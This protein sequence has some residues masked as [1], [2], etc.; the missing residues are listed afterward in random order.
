MKIETLKAIVNAFNSA[1]DEAT[2]YHLNHVCLTPRAGM[3]TIRATDGHILANF[4]VEDE[5]FKGMRDK[6]DY[7]VSPDSL[8]MLKAL[9]KEFKN[10]GEVPS[11]ITD[12]AIVVKS[13]QVRIEFEHGKKD[14][15][16]FPDTQA[17]YPTYLEEPTQIAFNPELLMDL[18]KSLKEHEKQSGVVLVVKNKGA[19]IRVLCG[20][21]EGLLMPM[22]LETKTYCEK[23]E[24]GAA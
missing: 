11:E 10:C 2:R 9:L 1:S 17:L 3:L 5:L 21:R 13:S 7:F 20:V 18:F 22:R 4:T 12:D 14:G 8:P 24:E 16:E 6:G 15:L 19:P 23:K